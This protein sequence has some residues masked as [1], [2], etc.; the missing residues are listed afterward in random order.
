MKFRISHERS[1]IDSI[2]NK[3]VC[4]EFVNFSIISIYGAR[5]ETTKFINSISSPQINIQNQI[6]QNNC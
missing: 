3:I 2:K 6:K 1:L 4:I 5:E